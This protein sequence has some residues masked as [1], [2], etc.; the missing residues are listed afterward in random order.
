MFMMLYPLDDFHGDWLV[1]LS[2]FLLV[3]WR[4]RSS[5][6]PVLSTA[7]FLTMLIAR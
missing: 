6:E 7:T 1:W 5:E 4:A 3:A 2:K